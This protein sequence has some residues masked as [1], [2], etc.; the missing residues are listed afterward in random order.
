MKIPAQ[1]QLA[2]PFDQGRRGSLLAGAASSLCVTGA[3]GNGFW[4][5]GAP[6][7]CGFGQLLCSSMLLLACAT[8]AMPSSQ[9]SV[10]KT[11]SL[12]G[13]SMSL[14]LQDSGNICCCGCLHDV[15][16]KAV[17]HCCC[18]S[19]PTHSVPD[20]SVV[21][22]QVHVCTLKFIKPAKGGCLQKVV[23]ATIINRMMPTSSRT[24]C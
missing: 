22:L 20:W 16:C 4:L 15:R 11:S 3:G 9:V 8:Q 17:S 12:G 5:A 19:L 18:C 1:K 7:S 13:L 6:A 14:G 2:H 21:Q 23:V 10:A 24:S